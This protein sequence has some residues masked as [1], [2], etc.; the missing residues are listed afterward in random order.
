MKKIKLKNELTVIYEE[1][2]TNSVAIEV[3]VKAGSNNEKVDERGISHFLEHMLFDGTTKRGTSKDI[4]NEIEKLG[5]EL[6]AYTSNERTCFFVK[7][8]S[9]H[10]D[11][12]LEILSDILQNPLFREEDIEREKK[13]VVKEIDMVNDGPRFYQWILFEKNV[14]E[15]H[16]SRF[17]TYGEKKVILGLNQKKVLDYYRRYYVPS[18]MVVS[19]VGKAPNWRKKIEGAFVFKEGKKVKV[20]SVVEGAAKKRKEVREKRKI[21]NSYVVLGFRTVPRQH[22]DSYVLDAMGGILGRGQ[23]G[24]IF[25]EVREKKG[26][27]YEVGTQHVSEKDYGY[28]A[29]YW[30]TDK[31]KINEA[32]KSVLAQLKR[33]EKTSA[34]DLAEAKTFVEGDY[35]LNIE[36]NLK[37]ADHLCFWEQMGNATG[38]WEYVN[39]VKKVTRADIR[40]VVKKYFNNYCMAVVEGK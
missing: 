12:G 37:Y 32:K 3:M 29:I 24:W 21:S 17:P 8:L 14:F 33:L 18:N 36:D 5:G 28:F 4:A 2:E 7:L 27:A 10:F 16:P 9:K 11:K 13:I 40:R 1:R 26:L 25:Q 20:L 6:N 23:S 30:S 22:K 15:K 31:V 35:Y 39:K 34:L 38:L 19:I